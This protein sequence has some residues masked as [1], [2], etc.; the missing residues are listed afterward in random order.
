[1]TESRDSSIQSLEIA[2]KN[3]QQPQ[4][5]QSSKFLKLKKLSSSYKDTDES[6]NQKQR[7]VSASAERKML[8]Q[9]KHNS[10]QNL[11]IVQNRFGS[12]KQSNMDLD[13]IDERT[14]QKKQKRSLSPQVNGSGKKIDLKKSGA[15]FLKGIIDQVAHQ[16]MFLSLTKE[17]NDRQHDYRNLF[18]TTGIKKGGFLKVPSRSTEKNGPIQLAQ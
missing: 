13:Q 5:Q 8:G 2:L 17:E 16:K 3:K 10:Q 9:S 6:K 4:K 12:Q 18:S 1:M 7:A 14:T 15:D 11:L